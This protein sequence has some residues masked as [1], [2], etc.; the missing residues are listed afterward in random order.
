MARPDKATAV[1]EMTEDFRN[2]QATVLTEYRGLTVA[3]MKQLRRALGEQNKYSVVKNTLTKIAARE[4]G[5][6]VPEELLVGP[7]AVAFINGDPVVAAKSLK[8][9]A[10]T[11]PLLV[12]KGGVLDGKFLTATEIGKMADLESREVLLSKMAG[13]IKAAFAQAIRSIDALRIKLEAD[14]APAEVVAEAP[15]EVTE[16]PESTEESKG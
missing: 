14:A 16:V 11:N 15:A 3:A 4:A 7:S 1:A 10:K 9:F 8:D 5:V 2:A 12:I 6:P 13:A